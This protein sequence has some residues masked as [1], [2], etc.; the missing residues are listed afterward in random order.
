M[1]WHAA[2][3]YLNG[4]WQP[5]AQAKVPVLDRGFMFGDGIYEV[6]PVDTVGHL[7]APFRAAAHVARLARGLAAIGIAN[8]HSAEQ[9][10][11]LIAAVL[12]AN[13]WPRQ[14]LY[15]QVTRGVAKR[16]HTFPADTPATVLA[17]SWPWP[18]IAPEALT[19]GVA[20]V[21]HVDERWLHCDIKSTS[22]LGNVLMKQHAATQHA[23]ETIL[24]RDGYLTEA[25][26][27]NV[28]IVQ[29][30]TIVAPTK[31][32]LILPGITYDVVAELARAHGLPFV[33]RPITAAELKAA[34]EVWLSSSGREVMPVTQ[35]DGAPVG[36]GQPGPLC[37]QLVRIYQ[38]AKE[39]DAQAWQARLPSLPACPGAGAPPA[40]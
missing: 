24:L 40:G 20:A 22:L 19:Q 39:A 6:I 35:L 36:N 26:T 21:T 15:L 31:N 32:H 4:T 1:Q 9:W 37:A 28:F 12:A 38:A 10:L 25:S 30:G 2:P 17:T 5:L 13:P 14:T 16:D 3:T 27:A 23:A 7:R 18:P 8:P 11:A 33:V 29:N 34:D